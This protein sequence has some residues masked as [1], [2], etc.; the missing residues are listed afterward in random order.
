MEYTGIPA[1]G[2]KVTASA[3]FWLTIKDG[4]IKNW[5][6]VEDSLGIM[7]QLGMEIMSKE[8]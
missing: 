4:R 8:K 7:M 6:N 3:I 2:K 5:W 1:T